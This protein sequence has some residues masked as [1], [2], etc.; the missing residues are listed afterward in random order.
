LAPAANRTE[1]AR[2]VAV[3]LD[4]RSPGGA[5]QGMSARVALL[6]LHRGGLIT[7]PPPRRVNANGRHRRLRRQAVWVPPAPVTQRVDELGRVELAPVCCAADSLLYHTLLERYHYLGYSALAGAQLRYLI[8]GPHGVLGVLGFGACAWRLQPRDRWIGWAETPRERPLHLILNNS[9]FLILPMVRSA[10]LG[11]KVLGLA[12]RRVGADF[13]AR[14]GYRPVLLES[15]VEEGRFQGTVYRAAN[16]QR[17]GAT[18]GRGKED[19]E[20]A[21][22]LPRK[23]IWLYPLRRDFRA[24]LGAGA[25]GRDG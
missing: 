19:R 12:A 7:L 17:V 16:W 20:H 14:Y 21:A 11:S 8:R 15:F 10:N 9:R 4:W 23:A 18:Q 25:P 24:L 22:A 2:R 6:R 3:A 5:H 1:L 13:A